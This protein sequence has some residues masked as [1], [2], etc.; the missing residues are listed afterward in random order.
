MTFARYPPGEYSMSAP[1][2][3]E[4]DSV[5]G[6]VVGRLVYGMRI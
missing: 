4:N 5:Q 3:Q 6:L 2:R 1:V